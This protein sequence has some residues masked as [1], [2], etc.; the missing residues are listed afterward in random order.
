MNPTEQQ[1]C[2]ILYSIRQKEIGNNDLD[3]SFELLGIDSVELI[4]LIVK[5]EEEF[6]IEFEEDMLQ[7]DKIKTIN[8]ISRYVEQK[9][10]E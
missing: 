8:I 10:N 4:E 5:V 6:G 9:M 1:I 3:T 7:L 2:Q